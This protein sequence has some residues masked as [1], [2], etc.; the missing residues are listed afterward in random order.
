M[1]IH[2]PDWVPNGIDGD[3][4]RAIPGGARLRLLHYGALDLH[5]SRP[6]MLEAAAL[7]LWMCYGPEN[8]LP[9]DW[10]NSESFLLPKYRPGG[11]SHELFRA[12]RR[13]F[14]RRRWVEFHRQ[15]R[16]RSWYRRVRGLGTLLYLGCVGLAVIFILPR[17]E[18]RLGRVWGNVTFALLFL[19]VAPIV[20]TVLA[21]LK[22]RFPWLEE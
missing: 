13:E 3:A 16:L 1:T 2:D 11:G 4:W 5:L 14:R 17:L 15:R 6:E 21:M 19:V 8:G 12:W 20:L 7:P 9:E 10:F 22:W 18:E